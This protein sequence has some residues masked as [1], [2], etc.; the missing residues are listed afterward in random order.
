VTADRRTGGGEGRLGG[1]RETVQDT[2]QQL[3]HGS[4]S[5]LGLITNPNYFTSRIV[6]TRV[7]WLT[8]ARQEYGLGAAPRRRR[9]HHHD[10]V[11]GDCAGPSSIDRRKQGLDPLPEQVTVH[12]EAGYD[13]GKTRTLLA[14]RG[15]QGE[16]AHKGEKAPTLAS[17]VGTSSAPTP[18][19]T[20]STG[21][22][23]L[24]TPRRR[25]RRLLRPRRRDHHCPSLIRRAWTSHRS[26]T[27]PARR[28]RSSPH[29]TSWP[30]P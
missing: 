11:R 23:A 22:N 1:G 20:A 8:L 6:S 13:S 9:V 2:S 5:S 17:R 30:R 3:G 7:A 29:P 15:L 10:S 24:R 26:H 4:S 28:P 21:C 16:I 25:D 14:E 19:T 12:L 18:G 27:R